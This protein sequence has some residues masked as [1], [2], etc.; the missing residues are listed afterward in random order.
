[1]KVLPSTPPS[2]CAITNALDN[3][4]W[5]DELEPVHMDRVFAY[6]AVVPIMRMTCRTEYA[7]GWRRRDFGV[8]TT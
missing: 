5:W 4:G 7:R 2:F 3:G 6:L 1:M 8:A